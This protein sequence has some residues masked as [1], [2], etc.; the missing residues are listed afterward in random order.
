MNQEYV[1]SVTYFDTD[2]TVFCG[3]AE[4]YL[5]EIN[6]ALNLYGIN[7]WK[8]ETLSEDK[9]LHVAVTNLIRDEFGLDPID[10]ED[11]P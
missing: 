7:G 11:T 9:K 2:D 1:G 10:E 4:E 3:S 6:R 8:K 5:N